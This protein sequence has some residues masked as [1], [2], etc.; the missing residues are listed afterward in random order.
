MVPTSDVA[1]GLS[2]AEEDLDGG[3]K[4]VAGSLESI[5]SRS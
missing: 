3:K 5:H 1:T 2:V 4:E